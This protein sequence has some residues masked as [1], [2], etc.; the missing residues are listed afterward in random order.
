[1]F[2]HSLLLE[3]PP[4]DWKPKSFDELCT[5]VQDAA[6]PSANGERLYL[7]LE[8]LA[9]G[10]PALVGRGTES[11]VRSGKT[12]FSSG[13]VLFGK[14][15][16]Y[17]RKSFLADQ[18]GICSTDILVFRATD[19][20]LPEFLCLLTNTN[21]FI[22]HAKATTS[23]VQHPRT[24]WAGLR[25]FALHVPPLG[26][27]RKIALLLSVVQ[28]AI[29]QQERLLA[30]TAELKNALLH[31]LFT[32]G[33]RGEALK[34]TE[35]GAMPKSWQL[36][37]CEELCTTITVG[38]VVKPAS[39]YVERGISAFRSFNVREDRLDTNDLVYFSK[40]DNDTA[41]AKSKLRTGDVLVVRTGYPGTSCVV[42]KEYDGT[43]CID[44]LIVRPKIEMIRSGFLSRFFN[45]P[46]GKRQAVAAKHG[47]AQQHLNVSAVKRTRI[48]VPS[49]NEQDDIDSAL[50]TVQRK[51]DIITQRKQSLTDLFRTLLHE[52]LTAQIRVN[53]LDLSQVESAVA[54]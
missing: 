41:L 1:M 25:E 52:L 39:H 43:N 15:R 47:L 20:C 18:C 7:G 49:L 29:Q 40:E 23:G 30:T 46:A 32:T 33:L 2:D 13:D 36:A 38:V 21:E 45:S 14:L 16:P 8:H 48:P 19:K 44:L 6:S 3:M 35:I 28:Q 34:E 22:D 12:A 42:P 4:P 31:Q 50:A 51:M 54:E 26:E 9:A 5:R 37:M 53:D 11:E 27:Q 17:L 24:S 10:F